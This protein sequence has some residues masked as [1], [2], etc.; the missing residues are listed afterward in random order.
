MMDRFF[1][2]LGILAFAAACATPGTTA[3]SSPVAGRTAPS[4]EQASFDLLVESYFEE[5][6]R[7]NPLLAT[8]IGDDRY[9]HIFPVIISEDHRARQR[10]LWEAYL[11][12]LRET[13]VEALGEARRLSHAM[14]TRELT[15]ELAGLA[16]PTHLVPLNQFYST[17]SM[18]AQLGSGTAAHRFRTVKDYD[19]FLMRIDGFEQWVTTAIANMRRGI[20][21]GVVQPRAL[22]EKV[23]PQLE[24]HIVE[25]PEKSVFFTPLR[26]FPA[27]VSQADRER[28]DA[29]YRQ[30][31]STRIVPAIRQLRDFVRDEYL[32]RSRTTAGL[33]TLPDGDAWYRHNVAS[34]TTTRLSPEEIHEIGLAEVARIHRAMEQ[35]RDELGFRGDLKDFFAHLQADPRRYFSSREEM[36][37]TYHEAKAKIDATLPKLFDVMPAA[38]YEIRPVETFRERS[39]SAGSYSPAT[40]DGSRPGIFYVNTYDLSARP[41]SDVT[42]LSLHEGN[43][44]HHF[45]ISIQRELEDLPRF[46]RF[47]SYTAYSEGWGLYAEA[48]GYELG[49]YDDPYQR[50]GQLAAE[51]WRAVRLVLDTGIHHKGWTREQAIQYGRDNSAL[52]ESRIVSEVERFM[53]IPGQALAYKIGQLEIA[54]LRRSAAA[55]LGSAFDPKA[56]HRLVLEDGALPLDLLEVKVQRW[57]AE[58]SA[59]S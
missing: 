54:R 52:G 13:D 26:N 33:G 56:F 39:A 49:L 5:T 7:L 38:D 14:L 20:A 19:D 42:A 43:P 9:N 51:L 16:F 24:A 30:A 45:Q 31:I 55:A 46:R 11:Q 4:P 48:L 41:R 32:P 36:L 21:A 34:I 25:E 6:L 47:G 40:P 23:V 58:R 12:R 8:S 10:A 27:A 53:A 3:P 50:F 1:C 59:S 2:C 57:V 17:P 15:T 18:F 44:G 35:V 37:Q 22:M 28:L 29:A